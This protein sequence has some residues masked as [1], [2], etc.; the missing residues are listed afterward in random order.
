MSHLCSP[1]SESGLICTLGGNLGRILLAQRVA[2]VHQRPRCQ[3]LS[4]GSLAEVWLML[5]SRQ[6]E[7]STHFFLAPG[8]SGEEKPKAHLSKY[9]TGYVHPGQRLHTTTSFGDPQ[10]LCPGLWP[11]Q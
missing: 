1:T 5:Q 4:S 10:W 9:Q 6:D 3:A 2:F 7:V 11:Q 8:P